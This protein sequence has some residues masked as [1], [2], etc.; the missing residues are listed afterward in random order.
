M[1]S[2]SRRRRARGSSAV[3]EMAISGYEPWALAREFVFLP[4]GHATAAS[5]RQPSP[6]PGPPFPRTPVGTAQVSATGHSSAIAFRKIGASAGVNVSSSVSAATLKTTHLNALVSGVSTTVVAYIFVNR[7]VGVPL[8]RRVIP[9]VES[10]T[11]FVKKEDRT[12]KFELRR[13]AA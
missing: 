1:H 2:G 5:P 11:V 3:G 4:R 13:K 10:R 12:Y 9:T 8:H 6:S 7:V